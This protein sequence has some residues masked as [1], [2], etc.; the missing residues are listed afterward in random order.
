MR[1]RDGL[2]ALL[3]QA[4]LAESP[5]SPAPDNVPAPT[6][7]AHQKNSDLSDLEWLED[8]TII[9]ATRNLFLRNRRLAQ[10]HIGWDYMRAQPKIDFDEPATASR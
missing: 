5:E 1:L 9:A 3:N 6:E 7:E 2:R 10:E 8:K 4:P